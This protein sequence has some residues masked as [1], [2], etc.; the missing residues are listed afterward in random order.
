MTTSLGRLDDF[1][2][3]TPNPVERSTARP[4]C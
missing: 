4:A 2:L 3:D 1:A